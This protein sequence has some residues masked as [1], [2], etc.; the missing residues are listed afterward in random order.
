MA[1]TGDK[2]DM[3][4]KQEV[5]LMIERAVSLALA[6]TRKPYE[7]RRED[8]WLSGAA[9][10]SMAE[11]PVWSG[12]GAGVDQAEEYLE[13]VEQV[14]DLAGWNDEVLIKTIKIKVTGTARQHIKLYPEKFNQKGTYGEFRKH[15]LD[16]YRTRKARNALV[17]E[18]L[19]T[20]RKSGETWQAFADRCEAAG[21][22][23]LAVEYRGKEGAENLMNEVVM[24]VFYREVPENLVDHLE[25]RQVKTI[26]EAVEQL[27]AIEARR[28]ERRREQRV[29]PVRKEELQES[30]SFPETRRTTFSEVVKKD[31]FPEV[32]EEYSGES[33]NDPEAQIFRTVSRKPK[34]RVEIPRSPCPKCRQMGHWARDC[35]NTFRRVTSEA[36]NQGATTDSFRFGRSW[37]IRCNG[38][39]LQGHIYARCPRTRCNYCDQKGHIRRDCPQAEEDWWKR[40]REQEG[41]EDTWE[42]RRG[43]LSSR[44]GTWATRRGDLNSQRPN[45]PPCQGRSY[46]R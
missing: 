35:P 30:S 25:T 17:A 33:D 38:C 18:L 29:Y 11:I 5:E 13:R 2:T 37:A 8:R 24:G 19:S 16:L 40:R 22:R 31:R 14:R 1:S 23:M 41:K 12:D 15:F 10:L 26:I 28:S 46:E 36:H 44:N 4:S 6:A 7:E 43:N 45:N 9:A 27:E 21:R 39:G 20:R 34:P 42:A 3:V 32:L